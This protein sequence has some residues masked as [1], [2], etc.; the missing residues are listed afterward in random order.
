MN[1]PDPFDQTPH[2]S[3]LCSAS[4]K[5]YDERR[6]SG[7]AQI[8]LIACRSR[9]AFLE[10]V[11]ADMESQNSQLRLENQHL[12]LTLRHLVREQVCKLLE[13]FTHAK[14]RYHGRA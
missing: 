6:R 11:V 7:R 14:C 10:V 5:L 4:M 1:Q 3:C 13:T 8:A 9:L 2:N 12:V